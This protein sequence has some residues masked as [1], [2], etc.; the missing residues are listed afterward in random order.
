MPAS[1]VD[2]EQPGAGLEVPT[3]GGQL[4][5]ATGEAWCAQSRPCARR[6]GREPESMEPAFVAVQVLDDQL[7]EPPGRQ[8]RRREH[9]RDGGG[10]AP[11][12]VGQRAQA[13]PAGAVVQLVKGVD[14]LALAAPVGSSGRGN[15]PIGPSRGVGN[16]DQAVQLCPFPSTAFPPDRPSWCP[17]RSLFEAHQAG[18]PMNTTPE[19]HSTHRPHDRPC[20]RPR[21]LRRRAVR[22]RD[23]LRDRR[24]DG[25]A[26]G[27]GCGQ[28]ARRLSP[29]NRAGEPAARQ[30]HQAPS[31]IDLIESARANQSA[32]PLAM[33]MARAGRRRAPGAQ[34]RKTTG[35]RQQGRQPRHHARRAAHGRG[36]QGCSLPSG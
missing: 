27:G 15:A 30:I 17:D 32:Y 36:R 4:R 2:H 13:R 21:R 24:R 29:G 14:Q 11:G 12:R 1:P 9:L 26:D 18:S 10:A 3:Y 20:Q 35:V 16:R 28:P 25:R 22:R 6:A 23:G 34:V 8:P 5:G 19:H 33:L 7:Q 31:S